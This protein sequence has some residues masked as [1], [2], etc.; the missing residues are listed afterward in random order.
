MRKVRDMKKGIVLMMAMIGVLV[1]GGCS[2]GSETPAGEDVS[3][4]TEQGLDITIPESEQGEQIGDSGANEPEGESGDSEAPGKTDPAES[5]KVSEGTD[6]SGESAPAPEKENGE[7][8][9]SFTAASLKEQPILGKSTDE[10]KTMFGEPAA[11][12]NL[13]GVTAWRYDFTED[14]YRHDS[15]V[16]S[17]DVKGLTSG[18]MQA[19]LMVMIDGDVAKEFY[20]YHVVEDEI[21]VYWKTNEKEMEYPAEGD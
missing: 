10:V 11:T 9:S 7:G 20:V 17:V 8:G 1:V 6:G 3:P 14:G 18:Q 19:Q 2:Q 13:P 12:E 5:G 21:M 16:A 4:G 15:Q